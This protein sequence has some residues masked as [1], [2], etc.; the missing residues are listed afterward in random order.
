M[1]PADVTLRG[2]GDMQGQSAQVSPPNHC[3]YTLCERVCLAAY[4]MGVVAVETE[5]YV[6]RRV[7]A[8]YASSWQG[9]NPGYTPLW[10]WRPIRWEKR[11]EMSPVIGLWSMRW[12]Q[13]DVFP[14]CQSSPEDFRTHVSF[15]QLWFSKGSVSSLYWGR[16]TVTDA[17]FK[18]REFCCWFVSQPVF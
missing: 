15:C 12:S 17:I 18:S 13:T 11:R 8:Q 5:G 10:P 4:K 9:F 7:T 1:S 14:R 6:I 3:N 16:R 2:H